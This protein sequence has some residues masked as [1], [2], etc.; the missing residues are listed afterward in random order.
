MRSERKP[1]KGSHQMLGF[2]QQIRERYVLTEQGEGAYGKPP[3]RGHTVRRTAARRNGGGGWRSRV[4]K[5]GS[6]LWKT[7][8][9]GTAIQLRA[10]KDSS[11]PFLFNHLHFLL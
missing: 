5:V 10:P 2:R 9:V 7:G 3:G 8:R 4:E 6:S 1:S 11:P